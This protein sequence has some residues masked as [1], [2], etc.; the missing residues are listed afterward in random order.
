MGD[1]RRVVPH[2]EYD[3]GNVFEMKVLFRYAL[4]VS[5]ALTVLALSA[6]P[7]LA[8]VGV[9]S[10][11]ANI[12]LS[13]P[14]LAGGSVEIPEFAIINT[15]DTPSPYAMLVSNSNLKD[16]RMS[17]PSSW[18]TF[19]PTTFYLFPNQAR[20]VR[21][22][23]HVSPEA[24]PGDYSVQ[25]IGSPNIATNGPGGYIG[26]G[27][28]PVVRFTVKQPNIWQS[29]GLLFVAWMP[30]SGFAF[31]ALVVIFGLFVWWLVSRR[32]ELIHK[33]TDPMNVLDESKIGENS[34]VY[35]QEDPSDETSHVE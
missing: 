20:H 13:D 29:I 11:V 9:G 32:K 34:T 27:V 30:W 7:A 33:A 2:C 31:A 4:L 10:S 35:T 24:K 1:C 23:I 25:I 15:G 17:A 18:L 3:E 14:V 26:V 12:K 16:S 6:H 8:S 19:E 28:G 21:P 5:L 22:T